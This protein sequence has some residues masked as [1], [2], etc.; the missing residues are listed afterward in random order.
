MKLIDKNTLKEILQSR[1]SSNEYTT[2]AFLPSP[3]L[4]KDI[5]K[6]TTRVAKA[7]QENQKITI[8]GDY[9]VD[10]V[11]STLIMVEFFQ[12]ANI[13]ID[14]IIP[15]RFEHGYG[16]SPKIMEIIDTDVAITVDNGISA[17]AAADICKEKG[18]D[19]IITDHHT[20][21]E[22]LPNAYAIVNPKQESCEFPFKDICGAQVAWYFCAAL[23]KEL[24]LNIDMKEFLDVLSIAIIAD[25]M[26][27]NSLNHTLVK[28]G[29][30]KLTQTKR[31]ALKE[32]L[33]NMNK[34]LSSDDIGFF[35]APKINSAGRMESAMIALEFLLSEDSFDA[36]ERLNYLNQLNEDRKVYQQRIIEQAKL[37]ADINDDIIV[38]WGED[39]HEGIIGIVASSLSHHFKR[40]AFVFSITEDKAKGSARSSGEVNLYE[41]LAKLDD[42]VLLGFGGHKSAAGLS[43]KADNLEKFKSDINAIVKTI[44]KT[45]HEEIKPLGE[46]SLD[47]VDFEFLDIIDSF[48]PYGLQNDKPIFQ[49]SN[50]KLI[51]TT[52]FGKDKTHLKLLLQKEYQTI[53]VIGFHTSDEQIGEVDNLN[54]IVSLNKNYFRG[55]TNI[56]YLLKAIV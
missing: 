29:M 5:K 27:M 52:K 15:N 14:Y 13:P 11:I 35:I 38:V 55:E 4:F 19:L 45:L 24:N 20:V 7:V 18:I 40:P 50:A 12:K 53:E 47:Q 1:H 3:Y 46:L 25:V 41:L 30:Q 49:I 31:V 17:H 54:L 36:L 22:T 48:E 16:I 51:N 23:K 21:G 6:A 37:E 28:S 26:P 44:D 2:L 34:T 9:D 43:L 33:Q 32:L 8:V 39:W 10:G 42:D 56:Q